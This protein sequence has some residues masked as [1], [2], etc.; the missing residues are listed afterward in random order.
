MK[1]IPARGPQGRFPAAGAFYWWRATR[2]R[3]WRAV[4]A[5]ALIGGLLGTVALGAL[6]GARRTAS[7]YGR[8]LQSINSSDVSVNLPG[9]VLQP[10]AKI[11]ALPGVQ[12]SAAVLGM[13]ALPVIRGRV[14]HSFLA[15]GL[16]GSYNGGYFRQD[17]MTVLAGRLPALDSTSEIVLNQPMARELGAGVGG[18]VTWQFYRQR[19]SGATYPAQRST[20]VVTGI[21]AIP[22]VLGDQFDSVPEAVLPPAATARY[23]PGEF[24][25]GWVE[26]R[27]AAG[28]AGLPALHAELAALSQKVARSL[29]VASIVLSIRRLDIVHHQVQEAIRP[30]AVALA[31]FG[32]LAALA[33][34]VLVGQ[35][36]TQL[37]SRSAAQISVLRAVGATRGQA[38]LAAGIDGGIAVLAGIMLAVAGAYAVSPLAPV[39]PIHRFDPSRGF[40]ADLLV[41]AGGGAALAVI[42]LGLLAVLAWRAAGPAA[43]EPSGRSS[44]I[45]G[46]AAAA[47]LPVTA[48]IGARYALERGTGQR[49]ASVRFVLAGSIAA[50]MAVV[51]ATVFGASLSGLVSHPARYGWNWDLLLQAEGGYGTWPPAV[52]QK[53]VD[54]QP[55]VTG[56]SVLGFT[57]L[58]IDGQEVPVM[59]L[60]QELGSVEP[61]TTSGQPIAGPGQ[62]EL[63][64]S[65]LH[66]LGK[67]LGD[68]VV[69]GSGKTARKLTVVGTVTLPSFGLGMADHVSLG[70]GALLT[71]STLLAIGGAAPGNASQQAELQSAPSAVAIDMAPGSSADARRVAARIIAANPDG[72]PGGTYQLGPQRGAAIANASQ[73]GSQPLALA[74]GLAAAAVLTLGLTVLASVRQR[75]RQLAVLKTLGLGRR[76]LRAIVAWQESVTLVIA[77][78]VGVP[79]GVAAGR[80][81]WASFASSVG[82][83]PVSVIPVLALFL[84]FL[85]LLA[86]G[87]LLA[88]APAAVA[89]RTPSA[90]ALRAE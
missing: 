6:A 60:Q 41:L 21:V 10:I 45:A 9:P 65:T 23:L 61:P 47:G 79:L 73:M 80:W 11:A 66:Q 87:N 18:K 74:L 50:V 33:M 2:R 22:P 26:L 58:L 52:M 31:I 77:A 72:D 27:L 44:A 54:G 82:A 4:V 48:V 34:L 1:T 17:K 35:G 13:D 84:G 25:F 24:A 62:I 40:Q 3:S 70:R 89:A 59:G 63:G 76:Q 67:H 83:V 57:Q 28:A 64:N 49:P 55:G 51:T 90:A 39:G 75:R 15:A 14:D 42:L 71:E 43:A 8:Y 88:A 36:L 30:Q 68:Q 46:A 7:A 85:A 16:A 69:V 56:W 20:F 81:A 19:P 5:V 12:D 32:G 78:V 53:L 37:L 29:G 38:A 86:A